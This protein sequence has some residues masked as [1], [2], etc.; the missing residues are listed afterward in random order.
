MP[1]DD[2]PRILAVDDVQ[3]NLD[4]I[5]D[6]F[7][8]EPCEIVTA[9]DAEE[10]LRLAGDECFDL[11]ILDVQMPHVDGYELCRRLHAI[12]DTRRLPVIFLT[13]HHTSA[14]D[15][16]RGLDLGACDYITKPFDVEELRARVRAVL[17]AKR[18]HEETESE[19]KA[20]AEKLGTH[21]DDLQDKK[22]ALE[23][24]AAE[25]E[26]LVAELQDTLR[27]ASCEP[28]THGQIL[29]V[30]GA[31]GGVGQSV[32]AANL[33]I[34]IG[35]VTK[36]RVALLDAD[37]QS[38]DVGALLDLSPKYNL[39]DLLPRADDLDVELIDAV[40]VRHSSGIEAIVASDG[41]ELN[42]EAEAAPLKKTL[43]ALREVLDYIVVDC[44]PFPGRCAQAIL[45]TADTALLVTTPEVTSVRRAQALLEMAQSVKPDSDMVLTVLNRYEP[46]GDMKSHEIEKALGCKF[47]AAVPNDPAVVTHSINEGVPFV[48]SRR[49]SKVSKCVVALARLIADQ[50]DQSVTSST[51]THSGACSS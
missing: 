27:Q 9:S 31:K 49:K 40:L 6:A 45:E 46:K 14:E 32:I 20:N 17:R 36:K 28:P 12:A 44:S 24:A 23:A 16:V 25:N 47:S 34:A 18:E 15:A 4:L 3:D 13:A 5:C 2:K 30:Y 50:R 37:I 29:A 8:D 39:S 21:V 33:A 38:G 26:R 35:G 19:L 1:P 42:E 7:E 11:A 41:L 43:L 51:A 22:R 48:L 10:A